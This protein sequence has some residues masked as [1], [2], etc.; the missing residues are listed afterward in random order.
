MAIQKP[1]PIGISAIGSYLPEGRI[2][3]IARRGDY[4]VETEF[5]KDKSGFTAVRRKAA[6]E[7]T[8][9][10][11]VKAFEALTAKRPIDIQTIDC[12]V[13]CTQNPD[14]K[15]LPHTSSVVHAKL[16]APETCAAFDISLGCSGYV[17]G[18]AVVKAFMEANGLKCGLLFTA[19]PYSKVIDETDKNTAILFGDAAAVTLLDGQPVWAIGPAKVRS[20][21]A[22]GAAIQTGADSVLRMNGRAVFT[23][24]ATKVPAL[25]KD[26]LEEQGLTPAGIDTFLLHQGSKFIVDTVRAAL[27]VS[28]QAAPF[29]AG[30]IGNSVSSTIPLMLES[31]LDGQEK[32]LV[33]A[34]FGVGLSWAAMLLERPKP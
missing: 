6:D 10:L 31:R 22:S 2:D 29:E 25:I 32:R 4:G 28:D 11:C 34:G 30:E 16:K 20:A 15:G 3:L 7:E 5:L 8:S 18:L 27:G 21:G 17:Y 1:R 12:I 13:V 9:D 26:L 23:F 14:G 33:L 24:S 19:D